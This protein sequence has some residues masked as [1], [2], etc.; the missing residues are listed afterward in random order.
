MQKSTDKREEVIDTKSELASQSNQVTQPPQPADTSTIMTQ[1]IGLTGIWELRS[2]PGSANDWR[3]IPT[4]VLDVNSGTFTG[5]TGCNSMSGRFVAQGTSVVFDNEIIIT[6]M[7]CTGKYDEN[8]FLK[9]LLMIDNYKINDT[10]LQLRKL[11]TIKMSF[12][13]QPI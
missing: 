9:N 10:M 12:K 13:R 6:K 3:R 11:D 7:G 8:V 4:L 1:A 5:N 2:M